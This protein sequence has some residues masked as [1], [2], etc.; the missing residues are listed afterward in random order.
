MCWPL[1]LIIKIIK[2]LVTNG[3]KYLIMPQTEDLFRYQDGFKKD[4]P[5]AVKVEF[6]SPQAENLLDQGFLAL[7][8]LI[9]IKEE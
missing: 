5:L 1:N 9:K 2:S 6:H 8:T 3:V 4:S 7:K